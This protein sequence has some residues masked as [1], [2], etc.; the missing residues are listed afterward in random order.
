MKDFALFADAVTMNDIKHHV[1]EM[2]LVPDMA[3]ELVRI[4]GP[5]M[6]AATCMCR[7]KARKPKFLSYFIMQKVM[8]VIT[9]FKQLLL[10]RSR[11]SPTS[12]A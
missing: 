1:R 5:L 3:T 2:Q 7:R 10:C 11:R 6:A 9:Y 8:L 4:A 12:A